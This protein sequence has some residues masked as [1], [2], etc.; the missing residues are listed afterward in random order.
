MISLWSAFF[1]L[2]ETLNKSFDK[3]RTNGKLL[4][5]FVV[6]LSNHE[7]NQLVQRFL[8][9]CLCVSVVRG[10]IFHVRHGE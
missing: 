4:I 10:F 9:L 5:P 1:C 2:S 3:L 7:R 8:S 6:S